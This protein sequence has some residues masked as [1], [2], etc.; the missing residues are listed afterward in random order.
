MGK[1]LK[2]KDMDACFETIENGVRILATLEEY[3]AEFTYCTVDV[4]VVSCKAVL[5]P[6]GKVKDKVRT[7]TALQ[8]FCPAEQDALMIVQN[9]TD[10]GIIERQKRKKKDFSDH[11]LSIFPKNSA[12]QA[13]TFTA[14]VPAKFYSNVEY[15][16]H[17]K[18]VLLS[19]NTTIPY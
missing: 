8:A 7:V 10:V 2:L 16:Q 9:F 13:V 14:K 6:K 1:K 3:I 15:V 12:K 18:G 11:H 4:N 5:T 19:V 17:K